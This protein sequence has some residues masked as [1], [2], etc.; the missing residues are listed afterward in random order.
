MSSLLKINDKGFGEYVAP[1]DRPTESTTVSVKEAL[2]VSHELQTRFNSIK[3]L[4]DISRMPKP[5]ANMLASGI[6][7]VESMQF[8]KL[9][10]L[11]ADPKMLPIFE[12]IISVTK[13]S[14]KIKFFDTRKE[15]ENWLAGSVSLS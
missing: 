1:A 11:G 14:S 3:Y 10:I 8:D 7:D 9:A 4:V 12:F 2:Q 13:Q 5:D 15:A 6:R